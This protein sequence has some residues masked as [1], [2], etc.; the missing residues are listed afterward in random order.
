MTGYRQRHGDTEVPQSFCTEEGLKWGSWLATQRTR[1]RKGQLPDEQVAQLDAL[2]VDWEPTQ[3]AW[4]LALADL[5]EFRR[6]QGHVQLPSGYTISEGFRLY[7]WL[8]T[9][10]SKYR[11][12]RLSEEQIRALLDLGIGLN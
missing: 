8:H 10:R 6:A 11:A 7:G 1:Y 3:T 12:G 9:Q 4:N 5:A 2:A